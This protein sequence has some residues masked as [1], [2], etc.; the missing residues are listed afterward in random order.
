MRIEIEFP[1]EFEKDYTA[2]KFAEFLGRVRADIDYN[3]ICG[4]YERETADVLAEA[5]KNS[6]V[7][8]PV[9][10]EGGRLIDADKL[11]ELMIKDRDYAGENGFVDMFY[12]RQHLIGVIN[13]QPTAYDVDKVVKQL[14][15][16]KEYSN[17]DFEGYADAHGLDSDD[18]W[19]YMG[20][21]RAIEI[22][23][24]GGADGN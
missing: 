1:E 10:Y 9:A 19:Y 16:E 7:V 23:K 24:G 2:D 21:K 4:N 14:E 15:E 22:V 13:Q 17:A 20:L 5:F 6:R 12:E 8:Q 11:I 3:G 18:D